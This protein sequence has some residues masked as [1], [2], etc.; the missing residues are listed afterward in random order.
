MVNKSDANQFLIDIQT[1]DI[2]NNQHIYAAYGDTYFTLS[3][4]IFRAHQGDYLNPLIWQQDL[5]NKYMN[6]YRIAI[7]HAFTVLCNRWK[8]LLCTWSSKWDKS[9]HTQMR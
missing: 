8:F 5:E 1:N 6:A 9:T 4:C 3:Q 2:D 7:E